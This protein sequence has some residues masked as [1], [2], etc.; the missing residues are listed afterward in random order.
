MAESQPRPGPRPESLLP[1]VFGPSHSHSS[2]VQGGV[3]SQPSQRGRGSLAAMAESAPKEAEHSDV[4]SA[5]PPAPAYV[6][7]SVDVA[8]AEGGSGP[9]CQR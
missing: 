7:P 2:L 1:S 5:K 8:K 9:G 4:E 3:H 6:P